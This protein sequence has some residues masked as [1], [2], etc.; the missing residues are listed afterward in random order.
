MPFA[1]IREFL[2]EL[3]RQNLLK[4]VKAP[5]RSHLEITEICRRVIMKNG[6]A[7]L[8]ENVDQGTMPV[9]GNLF[10]TVERVAQA[11]GARDID[12]LR[13]I[14]QMLLQIKA[15][16]WP[17]GL[18]EAVD[19]L[20]VLKRLWT[21]RPRVV[22]DAPVRECVVEGGDVDLGSIP[23]SHCWP[24]DAGRLLTFGLVITRTGLDGRHNV[25]IYRQ[26]IIG[27][28][29]LIMRWLAH[30]GGA[31]DFAHW[32]EH[33]PGKPF[34]VAVAI[35]A[36]PALTV[37]AVAPVPDT[38][39][40]YQFSGLLRGA[41]T[42]VIHT[43]AGLLVPARAEILLEGVIH[44]NDMALEGPFG[45][46]T[47]YYNG[48][49]EFP[50]MTV[51]RISHRRAPMYHTTYMGRS[52]HDEPSVLA[53]GLN[54]VFVPLLQ[55]QFPEIVDF[56]LPPEAC[57]YRIAVVSIRK[58]YPGHARRIMMGIWSYLR[59]FTYT[60]FVIIT[61]DD[62]NVRN[63]S[64]VI[65]ALVTRADPAR[66]ALILTDTPIDYLDF[67]SPLPGLGGKMGLDAT[68]K[69][70]PETTRTYGRPIRSDPATQDV[71]ATICRELG[72]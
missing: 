26:Q 37:A 47:G 31:M 11:I 30:R 10:G 42:E 33:F 61:D 65:W 38:L 28:N 20:P 51:T 3:E 2:A 53:M 60:K 69:K 7:V 18:H 39:S 15:P 35:G 34:P 24:E 14:G 13:Q 54:E 63:W 21:A 8:F 46:H 19:H 62:I 44:P 58:R 12:G 48:Q 6:P 1:D 49:D 27:R 36:D 43:E 67:A 17:H 59:Q 50:V 41:R 72:C 16:T 22:T 52:P 9:I 4:R 5:V 70:S 66:D 40:E 71:V 57:S 55:H 68:M 32:R 29:R 64:E 56:Y 45:D 25:A 23:I